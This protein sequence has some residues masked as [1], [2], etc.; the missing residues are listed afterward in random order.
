MIKKTQRGIWETNVKDINLENPETLR[1]YV[2]RKINIG[3]WEA[4]DKQSVA[5]LLPKL[6]IDPYLKQIIQNFI[7]KDFYASHNR[8]AAKAS[9]R[10]R[11]K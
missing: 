9:Y 2:E 3:D 4:L 10:R 7:D 11:R 1:F 8:S 6:N 5:A